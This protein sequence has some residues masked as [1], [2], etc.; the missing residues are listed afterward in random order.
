[1][2]DEVQE[3]LEGLADRERMALLRLPPEEFKAALEERGDLSRMER[4][5]LQRQFEDMQAERKR[6]GSKVL[7][8]IDAMDLLGRYTEL[9][10]IPLA[11]N[12]DA[13]TRRIETLEAICHHLSQPAWRRAWWGI[14][15][16]AMRVREAVT[17]RIVWL[18]TEEHDDGEEAGDAGAEAAAPDADDHGDDPGA[19]GRR[20]PE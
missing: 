5:R 2:S 20:A 17:S 6:W 9:K 18:N 10:M 13:A 8:R 16:W 12:L 14:L 19:E 1:M 11:A 4:R 3:T 15:A 7:T